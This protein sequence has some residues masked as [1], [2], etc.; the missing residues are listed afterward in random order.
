MNPNK[1][2]KIIIILVALYAKGNNLAM[3]S[4]QMKMYFQLKNN[5]FFEQVLTVLQIVR[6]SEAVAHVGHTIVA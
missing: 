4:T 2:N 5:M 1:N 3:F 6:K